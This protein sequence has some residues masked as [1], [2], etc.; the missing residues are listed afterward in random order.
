MEVSEVYS[1]VVGVLVSE[2]EDSD[3]DS[4][5][6]VVEVG[7]SVG[8]EDVE[9]E[10]L[11]VGVG[12]ETSLTSGGELDDDVLFC[13]GGGGGG[14][15]SDFLGESTGLSS[16]LSSLSL[17]LAF[18]SSSTT[19]YRAEPPLGTVTTQEA[20]PPAPTELLPTSSLTPCWDGSM[21]QGRP[22][23]PSPSHTISILK[24]GFSSLN[25]VAGSR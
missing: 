17:L 4:L 1:V 24:V 2:E 23:Q 19:T 13:C 6:V 12:V 18:E 16:F 15:G 25:G 11:W 3:N 7:V 14:E 8:V 22:L 20:A 5:E 10:E 9:L 21:A